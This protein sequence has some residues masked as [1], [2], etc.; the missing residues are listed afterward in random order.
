MTLDFFIDRTKAVVRVLLIFVFIVAQSAASLAVQVTTAQA[1][2]PMIHSAPKAGHPK[3]AA[4]AAPTVTIAG[5][6]KVLMGADFSLTVSFSNTGA[7]VGYGPFV[8]MIFPVN[9]K[10]GANNTNPPL[11]GVNFSSASLLGYTF[12]TGDDTLS[13]LTF[14]DDPSGT[15]CVDHPWAKDS[16]GAPLSICGPSGDQLVSLRLPFGSFVPGQPTAEITVQA[17]LSELADVNAGLPVKV[18][19]GFMYGETPLDDWCC[20]DTPIVNPASNDGSG[21]PQ[22]LILPQA[23]TFTKTYIGPGDVQDETASGPNFMR[24]YV[25]TVD[26]AEGQRITG[27]WVDDIIPDNM[28]YSGLDTANT[29]P[30]YTLF[31]EPFLNTPDSR[32][33]LIY[34]KTGTASTEDI[35][36]T[37]NFYIPRR[38]LYS[39]PVINASTG[40]DVESRNIAWIHNGTLHPKDTRDGL[41]PV[42]SDDSCP[43]CPPL[44]TLQDKSIA[45]QKDVSNV[46]DSNNSPT[47]TLEYTLTFQVSDFFAFGDVVVTDVISDGQHF[48]SSFAPTLQVDGNGYVLAVQPFHHDA[49]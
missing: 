36:V 8:D 37:Y 26:I 17:H 46:T 12:N 20:G 39:D 29:T 4:A 43:A 10:D 5:T 22:K 45:I 41:S 33:T 48:D 40:D 24:Q 1:A 13:V 34:S 47:D 49:T 6:G 19:G 3:P 25:L 9:G 31:S 15:G 28:Q 35:K 7:D 16:S 2:P 11:D 14:P 30:G 38:D 21:W 27:L 23:F 32:L 44:H 18:R 42:S